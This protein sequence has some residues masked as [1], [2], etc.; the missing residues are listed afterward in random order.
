MLEGPSLPLQGARLPVGTQGTPAE[1]EDKAHLE[2]VA[3]GEEGAMSS[4]E[5]YGEV[6]NAVRP[7]EG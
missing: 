7:G 3:G 5:K 1:R 2:G 6:Y 4:T